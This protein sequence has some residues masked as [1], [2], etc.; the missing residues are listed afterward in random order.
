M[1]IIRVRLKSRQALW[2]RGGIGRRAG[3]KNPLPYG[4]VGSIP[5]IPTIHFH[6]PEKT[7]S[8]CSSIAANA[9]ST[10]SPSNAG[11]SSRMNP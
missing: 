4:S 6:S 2:G 7:S 8:K 10:H 3:L 9:W 11:R 1:L 5:T